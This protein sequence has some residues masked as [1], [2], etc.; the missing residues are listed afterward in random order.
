MTFPLTSVG[1]LLVF[2]ISLNL[3][4]F[5]FLEE[6]GKDLSEQALIKRFKGS[7]L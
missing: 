5:G 4:H 3:E 7:S 1:F 6:C 2:K